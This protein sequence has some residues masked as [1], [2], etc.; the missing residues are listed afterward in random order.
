MGCLS[1][2]AKIDAKATDIKTHEIDDPNQNID[3]F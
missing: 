1:T 2:K 3:V